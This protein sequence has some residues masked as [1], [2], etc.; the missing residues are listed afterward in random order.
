[1][2]SLK[3]NLRD[4]TYENIIALEPIQDVYGNDTLEVRKIYAPPVH[5]QW[6]V[7]AAVGEEANEIFGDLTDYSRTVTLCGDCPVFEGDRVTFSGKTYTVVKIADS[8]NGYLLALREV[9]AHG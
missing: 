7:S 8:K 1:M 4:V 9:V 3:R 5:A 6:N 2:R